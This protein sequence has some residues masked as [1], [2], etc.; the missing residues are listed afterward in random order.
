MTMA[1]LHPIDFADLEPALQDA[2][3][4]RFERLGYLGDFFRVM[5][6]QPAALL[7]F[8]RFTEETKRALGAA[9]AELI[10]LTAATR[11]GNDYERHQHERLSLKL[12]FTEDWIRSVTALEEGGLVQRAVLALLED[13]GRGALPLVDEL[14][15]AHGDPFAV[16]VVLLAGRY[17]MHSTFVNAL[18][19]APPVASPL[20]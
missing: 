20:A 2:L 12:G 7:H 18:G 10:A 3:R 6:H 11:L 17:L 19:L 5:A 9:H 16:A 15:A 1:S 14:A 13:R 4:P 8:D